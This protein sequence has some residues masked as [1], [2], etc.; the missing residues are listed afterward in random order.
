MSSTIPFSYHLY[1]I[2]TQKHYYG[3]KFSKGCN[4]NDLWTTYFSSSK[5]VKH[6][7]EEYGADSF[8]VSI[9]KVFLTPQDALLWEHKVLRRLNASARDN[10]LNRHNGG[11]KFR[12]PLHHSDKTKNRLR[13]KTT[14]IKRSSA[15]KSKQSIKAILREE[16]RRLNGWKM[17][18]EAISRAIETRQE[19]IVAGIINPYSTS[20]N[21]KMGDSKRGT[22][23]KY[24]PDGS[25]IMI[26]PQQDQ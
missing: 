6:L 23:R 5:L 2:P 1:H 7:I 17:P 13:Q 20:R 21:K 19:R 24:F 18:K 8:D 3:I 11:T 10:W 26:K 4:P 15:T 25:F 22:K 12:A 9:R 14:G 16:R